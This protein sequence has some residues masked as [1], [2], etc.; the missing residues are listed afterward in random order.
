MVEVAFSDSVDVDAADA[1][2]HTI[3]AA[4]A[5]RETG[6][7]TSRSDPCCSTTSPSGSSA[8]TTSG[9]CQATG[10]NE[11]HARR[12]GRCAVDPGGHTESPCRK[13]RSRTTG[14]TA[15]RESASCCLLLTDQALNRLPHGSGQALLAHRQTRHLDTTDP[16]RVHSPS[17]NR[18]NATLGVPSR[19]LASRIPLVMAPS[20]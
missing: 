3:I 6:R 20:A 11:P 10:R 16:S 15:E 18:P 17:V 4:Q 19:R 1:K 5:T 7:P 12:H 14:E 13:R 9:R 8:A 2:N